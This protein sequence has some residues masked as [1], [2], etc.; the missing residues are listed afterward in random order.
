MFS[1]LGQSGTKAAFDTDLVN[2]VEVSIYLIVYCRFFACCPE[3]PAQNV[4]PAY[5]GL[6]AYN[7][8]FD[9]ALQSDT[10]RH[11]FLVCVDSGPGSRV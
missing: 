7:S 5:P 6:Y 10:V 1:R 2:Y 8:C 11:F 3:I 9:L 4:S